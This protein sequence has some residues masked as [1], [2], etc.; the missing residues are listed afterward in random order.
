MNLFKKLGIPVLA[1]G[2]SVCFFSCDK[3]VF[4]PKEDA[5][6]EKGGK[7]DPPPSVDEYEV[8]PTDSTDLGRG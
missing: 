2:M 1:I 7:L 8:P 4:T 6:F 5:S 3:E